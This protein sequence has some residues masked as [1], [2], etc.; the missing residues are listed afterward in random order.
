MTV[1]KSEPSE[2]EYLER[3]ASVYQQLNYDEGLA[4]YFLGKSH[5]WAERA[6]GPDVRFGEVLEVGAG[7][8]VHVRY[9]RHGFDKYWMTDLNVPFL[10]RM[11][12]RDT[13]GRGEIVVQRED[14]CAL[15][16]ANDTFDRVIATHVLEHLPQPQAVLREWARVLKPGGTLTLV[17]PCDPGLA[18]RLGRHLGPRRRFQRIGID[19]DYWM[20]R[21][22][23][24][25]IG[26]LVA[27]VRYFFQH[28]DEQW[29]PSRIP[30]VDLNLFYVAHIRVA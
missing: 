13:G 24:N 7:S 19:Y 14:A 8:A 25:P 30:S 28:V 23:V 20:A 6:F 11:P 21:E 16:F 29:L 17:L 4:G 2:A 26:N 1:L 9:V 27:F 22:H 10:E 12:R 15:S 3:W 5:E 18:W